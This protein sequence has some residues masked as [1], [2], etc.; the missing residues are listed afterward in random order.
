[1]IKPSFVFTDNAALQRDKAEIRGGTVLIDYAEDITAL[2]YCNRNFC[3]AIL[4][5]VEDSL[6]SLSI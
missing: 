6:Y 2:G 3:I 1:M 5:N 4:Y